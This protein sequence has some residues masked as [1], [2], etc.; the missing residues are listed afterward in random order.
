[1]RDYHS[2]SD[3]SEDFEVTFVFEDFWK[4]SSVY[5]KKAVAG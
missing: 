4:F 3:S 2:E 5:R 1:M